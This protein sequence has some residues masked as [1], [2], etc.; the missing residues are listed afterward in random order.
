MNISVILQHGWISFLGWGMGLLLG[1]LLGYSLAH[2]IKRFLS[3]NEFIPR[4]WSLIPWRT[5]WMAAILFAGFPILTV[6]HFG[7]GNRSGV[8]S[9]G[10]AVFVTSLV[11]SVEIFLDSWFPRP[12]LSRWLSVARTLATA[13]I[14]FLAFVG[15]MG[16]NGIGFI[17]M[18]HLQL[19]EYE[20]VVRSYLALVGLILIFD[21]ILGVVQLLFPQL[22]IRQARVEYQ[23]KL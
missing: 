19:M 8:I 21:I 20:M 14:V 2:G 13:A 11:W 10:L 15:T 12:L 7:L 23:K 1:G 6:M 18:Q 4:S 5:F 22:S 16:A 9:V 17:A 3:I